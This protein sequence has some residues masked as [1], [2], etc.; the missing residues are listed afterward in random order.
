MRAPSKSSG[1]PRELTE[2]DMVE[3]SLVAFPMQPLARVHM[4][5]TEA[6]C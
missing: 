6:G 2:L 4:V 1:A 3:V 5:L